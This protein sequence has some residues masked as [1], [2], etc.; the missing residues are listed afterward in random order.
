MTYGLTKEEQQFGWI[1]SKDSFTE[2][3]AGPGWRKSVVDS[4]CPERW[5]LEAALRLLSESSPWE[6]AVPKGVLPP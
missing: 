1:L 3:K 4:V 6:A 5:R 2:Q